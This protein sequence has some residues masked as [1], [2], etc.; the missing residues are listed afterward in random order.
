LNRIHPEVKAIL[1]ETKSSD[2]DFE[3]V[4]IRGD[5]L[6]ETVLRERR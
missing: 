5:S 4:T 3:P 6:S 1:G 2:R